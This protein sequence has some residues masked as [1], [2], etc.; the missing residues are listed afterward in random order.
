LVYGVY[1]V[2]PMTNRRFEHTHEHTLDRRINSKPEVLRFFDHRRR[3]LA[4]VIEA[5]SRNGRKR[6]SATRLHGLDVRPRHQF[7]DTR[8][9]P[10]VDELG[11]HIGHPGQRIDAIQLA[12]LNE[13]RSDCPVLCT[14]VMAGE[15]CV[16]SSQSNWPDRALDGIG[17]NLDAPIVKEAGEPF[18]VVESIADRLGKLRTLGDLCQTDQ[19]RSRCAKNLAQTLP[20]ERTYIAT[21]LSL[22]LA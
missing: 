4:P 9:R 3:Q 14:H 1:I 2:S 20:L 7:L 18:P 19:L 21:N 8:C 17:I 22:E 15:E 13:R 12:G 6:S 10:Q 5:S 11:E 16:F